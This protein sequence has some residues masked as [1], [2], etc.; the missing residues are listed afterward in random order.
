MID[1]QSPAL[2]F[3]PITDGGCSSMQLNFVAKFSL[4]RFACGSEL[5]Y[6][7]ENLHT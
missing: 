3:L 6:V 4:E 2:N 1:A 5:E 7:Y